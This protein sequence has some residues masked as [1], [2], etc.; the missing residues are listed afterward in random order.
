MQ[1]ERKF[2][3]KWGTNSLF[4]LPDNATAHQ[5]GLVKDFLAKINVTLLV[6]PPYSSDLDAADFY[7][8]SG[9]KSALKG[10][11][12]CD[13]TDIIKNS[14]E[15]RKRLSQNGFQ[16]CFQHICSCWQKCTVA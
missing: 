8:F 5:S 6:H 13:A 16:K 9:Q 7:L 11:C 1:P 14:T 3:Q 15:Q 10:L 12:F 4:L 2:P